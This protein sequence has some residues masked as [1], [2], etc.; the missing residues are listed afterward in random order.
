M[1][2]T[3][4]RAAVGLT[5]FAASRRLAILSDVDADRT[6]EVALRLLGA[7]DLAQAFVTSVWPR[8]RLEYAGSAVDCLHAMSM[9]ALSAAQPERRKLCLTSAFVAG[10]LAVTTAMSARRTLP[11]SRVFR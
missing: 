8:R 6:A 3:L 9:V 4:L 1:K 10:V 11:V 7:R 2:S 5:E